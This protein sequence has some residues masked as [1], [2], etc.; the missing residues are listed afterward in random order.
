M[1]VKAEVTNDKVTITQ[2]ETGDTAEMTPDEFIKRYPGLAGKTAAQI[3]L[4]R[5]D[6]RAS[7]PDALSP[8]RPGIPEVGDQVRVRASG[9]FGQ[10]VRTI[11][12]GLR[13]EFADKTISTFWPLELERRT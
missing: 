7:F 11:G 9:V 13:V 2:T 12:E 1:P 5:L 3:R 10:V 4:G 8:K 6:L